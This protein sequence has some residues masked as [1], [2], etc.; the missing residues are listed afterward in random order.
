MKTI[1][2]LGKEFEEMTKK[3]K[4]ENKPSKIAGTFT[5]ISELTE[6]HIKHFRNAPYVWKN[7]NGT[8]IAG[9]LMDDKLSYIHL[10]M[11]TEEVLTFILNL[12]S[13]TNDK[14]YV[15]MDCMEE[16]DKKIESVETVRTHPDDSEETKPMKFDPSVVTGHPCD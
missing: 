11:V 3:W 6:E 5:K 4:E 14:S 16:K 8:L 10:V 13:L 12:K 9:M 7:I 1:E 2:E 15:K